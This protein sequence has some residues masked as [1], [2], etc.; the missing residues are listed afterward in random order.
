MSSCYC[1][2]L[3]TQGD[4]NAPQLLLFIVGFVIKKHAHTNNQK[5]N[6]AKKEKK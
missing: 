6:K 3:K 2:K 1:C 4:Y 5:N